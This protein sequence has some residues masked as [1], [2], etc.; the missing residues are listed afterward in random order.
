MQDCPW[1]AGTVRDAPA[2]IIATLNGA[3]EAATD[4][5]GDNDVTFVDVTDSLAGHEMCTFTP[6]VHPLSDGLEALHATADGYEAI[7]HAVA[8]A[9]DR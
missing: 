1:L 9:L 6:W 7:G 3:L 2:E 8:A 4:Q 5:S